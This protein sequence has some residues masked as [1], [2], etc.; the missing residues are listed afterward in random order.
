[1]NTRVSLLEKYE[2]QVLYICSSSYTI[3]NR[4]HWM[5]SEILTPQSWEVI[6]YITLTTDFTSTRGRKRKFEMMKTDH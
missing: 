5:K 1:M 3:C 4:E 6:S 2:T